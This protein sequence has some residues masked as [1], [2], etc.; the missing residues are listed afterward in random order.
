MASAG[1]VVP[2][3]SPP[4]RA[5][6]V[7]SGE[8]ASEGDGHAPCAMQHAHGSL[9]PVD[10]HSGITGTQVCPC[11]A[12][13]SPPAMRGPIITASAARRPVGGHAAKGG[14]LR[15]AILWVVDQMHGKCRVT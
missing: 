4:A 7:H 12:I 5:A 2:T 9:V 1:S 15:L 11:M 14:R 6:G 8:V 13:M 3:C 10:P